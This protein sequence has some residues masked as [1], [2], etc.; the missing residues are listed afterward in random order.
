VTSQLPQDKWHEYLRKGT[1]TT[2]DAIMDRLI[3]NASKIELQGASLR[4]HKN[5]LL[6]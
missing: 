6:E 3:T 4:P 2:A 5:R 1:P